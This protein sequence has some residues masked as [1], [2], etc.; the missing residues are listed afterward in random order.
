MSNRQASSTSSSRRF[1][2]AYGITLF[3]SVAGFA[4]ASEWLIRT[5]VDQVHTFR[6]YVALFKNSRAPDI[7]FGDSITASGFTGQPPFLNLG[8]GGD[9][10]AQTFEKLRLYYAERPAR[11]VILEAGAHH[12]SHR[13]IHDNG[14]PFAPDLADDNLS[15]LRVMDRKYRHELLAFWRIFLDHGR[16]VPRETMQPDG[17]RLVHGNYSK[18]TEAVRRMGAA[19]VARTLIPLPGFEDSVPARIYAQMLD[20]LRD[21][22]AD[23]CLVTY[24]VA[25]ALSREARGYASFAQVRAMFA[26][27]AAERSITYLD[28][29]DSPL[30]ESMFDDENH[31]NADGAHAISAEIVN[32]C[33][34]NSRENP[35]PGPNT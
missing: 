10:V 2:L 7:A 34:P 32:R 25:P 22:N 18:K 30:P 14:L 31:L 26:R 5:Q 28:L 4:V 1:A 27:M 16:F 6:K 15:A 11:R 33:F 23:V 20:W 29:F 21:K 24:P 8:M 9:S 12:F 19:Q 3:L 35:R 13:Y 17:A